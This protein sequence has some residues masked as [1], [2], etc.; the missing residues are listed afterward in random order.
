[1]GENMDSK[2]GN[3]FACCL[4]LFAICVVL[5]IAVMLCFAMPPVGLLAF[6]GVIYLVGAA[7][8]GFAEHSGKS[9][10]QS[11]SWLIAVFMILVLFIS[12]N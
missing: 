8:Q 10:K 6:G 3:G 5:P 1:M 2:N 12:I 11:T 4:L 7:V 9:I